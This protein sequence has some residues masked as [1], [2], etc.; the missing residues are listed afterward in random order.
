LAILF[1]AYVGLFIGLLQKID[2]PSF[3]ER[4]ANTQGV[5]TALLVNFGIVVLLVF[6]N[7]NKVFQSKS[8]RYACA[9]FGLTILIYG[10]AKNFMEGNSQELWSWLNTE[11]I[12]YLLVITYFIVVTHIRYLSQR[13]NIIKNEVIEE[14]V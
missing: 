4:Y 2:C 1:F 12:A 3:F 7:S 14:I 10:H 5:F 11:Y 8:N 13:L 6:D 9:S